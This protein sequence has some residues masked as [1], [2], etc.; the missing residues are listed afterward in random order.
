MTKGGKHWKQQQ[1]KKLLSFWRLPF[2][3]FDNIPPLKV[4]RSYTFYLGAQDPLEK[5]LN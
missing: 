5:T 1:S 2:F 4:E 3:T